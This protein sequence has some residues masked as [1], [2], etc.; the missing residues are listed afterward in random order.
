MP[1]KP[2]KANPAPKQLTDL[3]RCAK[4]ARR[5]NENEFLTADGQ[6]TP[7]CQE[8]RRLDKRLNAAVLKKI[9]A[10]A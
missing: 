5:A 7:Y 10:K 9:P 1:D 4:C 3:R 8:C 6:P 2:S